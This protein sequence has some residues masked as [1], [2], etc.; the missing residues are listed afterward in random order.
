M[1]CRV[2]FWGSKSPANESSRFAYYS[3]C[4]GF[5]SFAGRY[6]EN[7]KTINKNGGSMRAFSKATLAICW[8][9]AISGTVR[10]ENDEY[11]RTCESYEE[12]FFRVS[13]DGMCVRLGG[14]LRHDITAGHDIDDGTR[15][16]H[17]QSKTKFFLE[18]DSRADTE[19]GVLKSYGELEFAFTDG[20][21]K[22]ADISDLYIEL[23]G[24][25]IGYSDSIYET[26]FDWDNGA[27]ND[28]TVNYSGDMTPVISFTK[29]LNNGFSYTIGAEIGAETDLSFVSADDDNI[30]IQVDETHDYRITG[31]M[32]HVVGGIKYEAERGTV[33]IA[34]GYDAKIREVGIKGRLDYRLTDAIGV[35]TMLGYQTNGEKRN[36]YGN[37]NGN[38]A[39][40]AGFFTEINSRTIFNFQVAYEDAGTWAMAGDFNFSVL[41]GLVVTPEINYTSFSEKRSLHREALGGMLRIKH[42][43]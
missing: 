23:G 16:R 9:L 28:D 35:F 18:I 34:A 12:G 4:T 30:R 40:W 37:W 11:I 20:E 10:A 1:D 24:L 36:Y 41:P 14:T 8:V 42:I 7:L 2:F 21:D 29:N 33:T 39:V 19:L 43:F 17:L 26:W 32:P 31:Y 25:K 15:Y 5:G 27:I 38:Y 6:A 22:G 13:E 3:K